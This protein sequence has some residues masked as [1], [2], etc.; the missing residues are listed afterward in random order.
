MKASNVSAPGA[1]SV[2]SA[3]S[4]PEKIMSGPALS[5]GSSTVSPLLSNSVCEKP[6]SRRSSLMV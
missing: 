2:P 5:A 6:S 4:Q 3:S 1:N